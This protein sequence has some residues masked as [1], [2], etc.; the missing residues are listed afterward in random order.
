[1]QIY[2][3]DALN[4]ERLDAEQLATDVQAFLAVTEAA[5]TNI[6]PH[7]DADTHTDTDTYAG[8]GTD[9]ST[10]AAG[11]SRFPTQY[12]DKTSDLYTF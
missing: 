8:S 4:G 5:N 2:Y 7:T 11:F 1:M 3:Y 10:N 12:Y 9:S 6:I